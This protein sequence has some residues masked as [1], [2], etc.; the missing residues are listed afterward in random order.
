MNTYNALLQ[1]LASHTGMVPPSRTNRGAHPHSRDTARSAILK[2]RL[3]GS[4][5]HQSPTLFTRTVTV[6]LLPKPAKT[7]FTCCC[8]ADMSS[9]AS[10]ARESGLEAVFKK[11]AQIRF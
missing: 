10:C 9:S 6:L 5:T 7:V 2:S 1:G 4:A 3:S 11:R 8:S